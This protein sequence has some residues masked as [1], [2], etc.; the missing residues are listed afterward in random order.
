MTP[1]S[2]RGDPGFGGLPL[3]HEKTQQRRP[4]PS[5][6]SNGSAAHHN[7]P[8]LRGGAFFD[9]GPCPSQDPGP[10]PLP[11]PDP[12]G[13]CHPRGDPDPTPHGP[14][15]PAPPAPDALRVKALRA[16]E[17]GDGTEPITDQQRSRAAVTHTTTEQPSTPEP[18][19]PPEQAPSPE[20]AI[21]GYLY[22]A[23]F[24]TTGLHPQ[25]GVAIARTIDDAR[26]RLADM[27]VEE[28]PYSRWR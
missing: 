9:R 3:L 22:E 5:P 28:D 17:R 10:P 15:T 25:G 26:Q 11:C 4:H 20:S 24:H 18:A 12:S 8:P 7:N 14:G 6:Q 16:E 21:A 19:P 27:G 2:R 13:S 1:P 23:G